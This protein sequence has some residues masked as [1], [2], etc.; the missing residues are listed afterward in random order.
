M[1]SFL[2][3]SL[4]KRFRLCQIGLAQVAGSAPPAGDRPGQTEE[5]HQD[6]KAVEE[7]QKLGG[8]SGGES[9][10]AGDDGEQQKE[11]GEIRHL[12]VTL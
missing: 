6:E 5:G 2:R 7:L 3:L 1:S 11:N 4:G 8:G 12:A 9:G 10:P